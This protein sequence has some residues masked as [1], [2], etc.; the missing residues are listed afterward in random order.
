MAFGAMFK[1][2]RK[3]LVGG[4]GIALDAFLARSVQ[5]W[6]KRDGGKWK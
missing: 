1:P 3:L 2:E 6:V 5:F 4:D